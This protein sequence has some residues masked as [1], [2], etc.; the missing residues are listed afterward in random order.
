[1]YIKTKELPQSIQSC[2]HSIGYGKADIAIE[3]KET[4]NIS[5]CAGDGSRSYYAIVALDGSITPEIHYGSWGGGNPFE[6]KRVDVDD[7]NYPMKPECA[8]ITGETGGR[9]T[10]ARITLHPNNIAA[11]LPPKADITDEQKGILKSYATLK[12]AYRPKYSSEEID[13]LVVKGLLK[14]SKNG[15]TQ[16]TTDGKNAIGK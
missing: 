8:V 1:M 9:G 16:I 15:A 2:L 6:A 11:M 13:E 7:T 12:P 14:R 4:V 10:F 3:A 5:S